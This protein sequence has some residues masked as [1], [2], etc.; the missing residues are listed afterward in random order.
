MEDHWVKLAQ[1][2]WDVDKDLVENVNGSIDSLLTFVRFH[3]LR[4]SRQV[5]IDGCSQAGLLSAV[6]S[7]FAIA[8]Y[9]LLQ[10]ASGV[11]SPLSQPPQPKASVVVMNVFVFSSLA[12]ALICASVGILRKTQLKQHLAWTKKRT[13]ARAQ[14]VARQLSYEL[15]SCRMLWDSASHFSWGLTLSI[16]LFAVGIF[17]F[18]W[19]M[20]HSVAWAVLVFA[21]FT[22]CVIFS[23]DILKYYHLCRDW[24]CV[25][26]Y[27]LRCQDW[28]F[29][30]EVVVNL[31]CSWNSHMFIRETVPRP[32]VGD[33]AHFH[34]LSRAIMSRTLELTASGVDPYIGRL[35]RS[36]VGLGK[37]PHGTGQK[38]VASEAS[39][40][41]VGLERAVDTVLAIL[42]DRDPLKG[43]ISIPV[44]LWS[45]VKG[46]FTLTQPAPRQRQALSYMSDLAFMTLP[47][48]FWI[49]HAFRELNIEEKYLLATVI[50]DQ[51]PSYLRMTEP[52]QPVVSGMQ[53]ALEDSLYSAFL[54]AY[55][56]RQQF[57]EG[58]IPLG[59][60]D[61]KLR[62]FITLAAVRL[63][64]SNLPKGARLTSARNLDHSGHENPA[65]SFVEWANKDL[66]R[67]I[68]KRIAE[69]SYTV[70]WWFFDERD[71]LAEPFDEGEH[72]F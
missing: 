68:N 41:N 14:I 34:L 21:C 45:R 25:K 37:L 40:K 8:T 63:Q 55:C 47:W 11:T 49:T 57:I 46:H 58:K 51:F 60:L 4:S 12:L 31:I 64:F 71:D 48:M 65:A 56:M 18:L 7:A 16:G 24:I 72:P 67:T 61:L 66:Q 54:L 30:I 43:S 9:P 62:Q 42:Q 59:P 20:N 3:V 17:I 27:W 28:V 13:D 1:E 15:N 32:S 29:V 70:Y 38:V 6:Q 39:K 22:L 44:S 10:P 52:L 50:S 2:L 69:Y 53:P 26:W 33:H 23:R 35:A 5:L 19:T 36:I